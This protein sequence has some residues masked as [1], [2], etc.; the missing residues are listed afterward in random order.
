MPK[1]VIER[2]ILMQGSCRRS[3]FSNFA[4]IMRCVAEA[5]AALQWM[6]AT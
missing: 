3:N 1:Y 5:G 2:E 4:E 6:E